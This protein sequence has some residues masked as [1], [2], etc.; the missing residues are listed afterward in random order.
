M[1]LYDAAELIREDGLD[2][3]DEVVAGL[4]PIHLYPVHRGYALGAFKRHLVDDEVDGDRLQAFRADYGDELDRQPVPVLVLCLY[5]MRPREL[6]RHEV[7]Q[8][9]LGKPDEL[10]ERLTQVF[11]C[12]ES[13]SMSR[14]AR[15]STVRASIARPP[16]S[17]NK[18]L[19]PENTRQR[20]RWK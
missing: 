10:L 17:T 8:V 14:V 15:A 6:E 4:N 9:G 12:G 5:R 3:V 19:P 18:S 7:V 16:L 20:S 11:F 2:G 13:R 1:H